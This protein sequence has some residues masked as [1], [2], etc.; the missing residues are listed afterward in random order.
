MIEFQIALCGAQ[1]GAPY[2]TIGLIKESNRVVKA[3]NETFDLIKTR[4][5][6]NSALMALVLRLAWAIVNEPE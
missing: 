4:L 2:K 1:I 5:S 3:L 6:P